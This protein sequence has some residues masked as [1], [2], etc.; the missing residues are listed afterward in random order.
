MPGQSSRLRELSNGSL[1]AS[2]DDLKKGVQ[3]AIAEAISPSSEMPPDPRQG[4]ACTLGLHDDGFSKLDVLIHRRLLPSHDLPEGT[5]LQITL[6][7]SER[8]LDVVKAH[9]SAP[10]GKGKLARRVFCTLYCP[11]FPL[12]S[13][14]QKSKPSRESYASIVRFCFPRNAF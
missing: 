9:D 4:P 10:K 13:D 1:G 2:K 11:C 3:N 14:C 6:E 7:E 8:R 5:R 12:K